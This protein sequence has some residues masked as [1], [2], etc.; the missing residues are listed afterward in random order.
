MNRFMSR[1]SSDQHVLS[2]DDPLSHLAIDA[3]SCM[4]FMHARTDFKLHTTISHYF[5]N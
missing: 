4:K 3:S 1:H 2:C 5:E